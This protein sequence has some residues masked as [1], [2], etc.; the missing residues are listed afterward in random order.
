MYKDERAGMLMIA[1]LLIMKKHIRNSQKPFNREMAMGYH[2]V[3]EENEV[4]QHTHVK[5]ALRNTA[6]SEN[7]VAEQ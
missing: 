5:R 3:I 4:T 1:V 6:V 7:Q 2:A